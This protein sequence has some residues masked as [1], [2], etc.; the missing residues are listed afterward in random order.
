MNKFFITFFA[1]SCILLS[2][3]IQAQ[4]VPVIQNFSS[5]QLN[6]DETITVTPFSPY[7]GCRGEHD[8]CGAKVVILKKGETYRHSDGFHAYGSVTYKGVNDNQLVFEIMDGFNAIS[9]G[10][11]VSEERREKK[12]YPY[13]K[14]QFADGREKEILERIEFNEENK[15]EI[16]RLIK[17]L[18]IVNELLWQKYHDLEYVKFLVENGADINST[19]ENGETILFPTLINDH[20]SFGYC[21][22]EVQILLALIDFG[23]DIHHKDNKNKEALDYINERIQKCHNSNGYGNGYHYGIGDGEDRCSCLFVYE[24]ILKGNPNPLEVDEETC[25]KLPDFE[26]VSY[27]SEWIIDSVQGEKTKEIRDGKVYELAPLPSLNDWKASPQ[28]R[29]CLPRCLEGQ[30]RSDSHGCLS[31][32]ES[33]KPIASEKECAKCPNRSSKRGISGY[34]D[35]IRDYLLCPE[36]TIKGK[37]ICVRNDE[38]CL[39]CEVEWGITTTIEECS[40]CPNRKM[41]KDECILKECPEGEFMAFGSSCKACEDISSFSSTK[42]EDCLKCPNRIMY[43]GKF[44]YCAPKECPK[45]TFRSLQL[46][47]CVSCDESNDTHVGLDATL[48]ECNKCPE[49]ELVGTRCSLKV[50]PEG[51]FRINDGTCP[52]CNWNGDFKTTE[53][54][55]SKCLGRVYKNGKCSLR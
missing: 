50:C 17:K 29:S 49:R 28:K 10:G 46:G 21:T 31:C 2:S 12:V 36:G 52:S 3:S 30:F 51:Q 38:E 4:S 26:F 35:C 32:N 20:Q 41:V 40:K 24:Q 19:N 18:G 7:M 9:F 37:S 48:E 45:G 23:I 42:K 6:D 39:S 5:I 22:K 8:D 14:E 25:N 11:G 15:E 13:T 55:C 44:E 1:V 16:I 43:K 33:W 34:L 47:S 54:Q 27:D 53:E